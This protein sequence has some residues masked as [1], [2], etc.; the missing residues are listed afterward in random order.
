MKR[1]LFFHLANGIAD[2]DFWKYKDDL[3]ISL[4]ILDHVYN[5]RAHTHRKGSRK[6]R[7]KRA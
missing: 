4:D 3:N 5:L 6:E 2:W 7:P 1:T